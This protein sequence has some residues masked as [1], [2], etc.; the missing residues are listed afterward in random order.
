MIKI[1]VSNRYNGDECFTDIAIGG[2][3]KPVMVISVPDHQYQETISSITDNILTPRT[4]AW[5]NEDQ[6]SDADQS[7]EIDESEKEDP[8]D[9][10]DSGLDEKIK[11]INLQKNINKRTKH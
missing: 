7:D 10:N 9:F 5:E 11:I 2:G 4:W 6:V 1:E 3:S 8:L